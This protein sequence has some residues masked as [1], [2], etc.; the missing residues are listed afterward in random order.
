MVTTIPYNE[1]FSV[2]KLGE[3][4]QFS[5]DQR[6]EDHHCPRPQGHRNNLG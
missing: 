5:R 1:V 3:V 2:Y 6:F 4:F